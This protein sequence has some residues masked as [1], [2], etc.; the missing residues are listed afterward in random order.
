MLPLVRSAQRIGASSPESVVALFHGLSQTKESLSRLA[1]AWAAQCPK[2]QFVLMQAEHTHNRGGYDWFAY[3]QSRVEF[4]TEEEFVSEVVMPS[5]ERCQE[6]VSEALDEL[7]LELELD[8]SNLVLAGFSQGAAVAAYT[9]LSRGVAGVF[10]MG[11]PCPPRRELLP[12]PVSTEVCVVSGQNDDLAPCDELV[13][14]FTKH[15][16]KIGIF[17]YLSRFTSKFSLF[18]S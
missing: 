14:V 16:F 11:G 3:P 12:W 1:G 2:T 13:D 17:R 4:D 5:L 8:D 7:L 15:L 6:E 18:G 10:L 9:G